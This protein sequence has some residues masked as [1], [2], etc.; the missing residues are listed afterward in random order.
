MCIFV[1]MYGIQITAA[2]NKIHHRPKT[3]RSSMKLPWRKREIASVNIY[4]NIF[5]KCIYFWVRLNII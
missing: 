2:G 1:P 3:L 5:S 4:L